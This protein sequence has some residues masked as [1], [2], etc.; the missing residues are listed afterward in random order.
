MAKY[1]ETKVRS[2]RTQEDGMVKQVVDHY[3][4]EADS[5]TE[6]EARILE[7]VD[8]VSV[9]SVTRSSVKELFLSAHP[10]DDTFYKAKVEFVTI[11]ERTMKE[12]RSNHVILVQAAG[13][14]NAVKNLEN[15]LS[16]TMSDYEI[17]SLTK[18]TILDFYGS[19]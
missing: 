12:K 6:A 1:I 3:L 11:D 19:K 5:F 17:V 10:S 9:D 16:G 15:G 4:V 18:T 8:A 14:D 13:F 2:E 7:E